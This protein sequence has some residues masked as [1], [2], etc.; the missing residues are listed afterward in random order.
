MKAFEV[1]VDAEGKVSIKAV[2]FKGNA[3]EKASKALEE[4]MGI[5]TKSTKTPDWYQQEQ[6]CQK[7][8]G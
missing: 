8:G 7:V 3:C 6:S 2:G 4:A 5:T 1:I